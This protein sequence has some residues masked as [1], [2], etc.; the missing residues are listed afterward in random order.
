MICAITGHSGLLGK[1]LLKEAKNNI[2]FIKFKGNICNKKKISNWIL[3]NNFDAFIHLAAIVPTKKVSRDY[4]RA[5]KVNFYGTKF[6]IDALKKKKNKIWFFYSSSS[7]VYASSKKFIKEDS[8][9]KPPNSYGK[10]KLMA[11]KYI[12]KK[13]TNTKVTYCIGRIFSFTDIK[14]ASSFFIPF[15]FY[16]LKREKNN[17][18][19]VL[20]KNINHVR[21]FI[22]IYELSKIILFFLRYNIEGIYNIG[23]GKKVSLKYIIIKIAEFF[24]MDK[25][26]S[27]EKCYNYKSTQLVANIKKIKNI[28]IEPKSNINIILKNYLKK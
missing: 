7:H 10:L 15:V 28:G 16:K 14:Q 2:K 24:R 25:R 12:I 11:E 20:F 27:F 23:S 18:G 3:N 22:S 13:L 6:V 19:N 8:K 4:L 26:V 1:R 9:L 17:K 21:D 5:K